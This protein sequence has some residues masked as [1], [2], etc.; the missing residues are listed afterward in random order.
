[1]AVVYALSCGALDEGRFAV[2]QPR[3]LPSPIM[4]P[5]LLIPALLACRLAL[6]AHSAS[7]Q[8][9]TTPAPQTS[10]YAA[11]LV[12]GV[13]QFDLSGTGTTVLV[14]ARF[15]A[16]LQRWLVAEAALQS[17]QPEEQFGVSARYTIP[18]VQ[19]QLQYPGR[20]VRP[21][22]G[23]GG[24]YVFASDGREK[25]GT[26]SGAVGL[27]IGPPSARLDVLTELRVR[28]IG[29][30]FGGSTAEWTLGVVHRF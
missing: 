12:A 7:A 8:S 17:I 24:G 13:S 6:A 23:V 21:Y 25:Q 15:A 5:R 18:E 2:L 26:G 14:G 9:A 11:G 19:L 29:R 3:P 16:D 27:G 20:V 1:M 28:G 22:L 4:V 10:R 30:S